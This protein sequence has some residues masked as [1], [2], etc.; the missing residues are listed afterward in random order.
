MIY[1]I[2]NYICTE[3]RSHWTDILFIIL[4]RF[5]RHLINT[6][7]GIHSKNISNLLFAYYVHDE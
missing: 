4:P 7:V 6:L 5:N 2:D 1:V 3:R